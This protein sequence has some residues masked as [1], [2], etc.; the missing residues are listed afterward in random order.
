MSDETANPV[1]L[2]RSRTAERFDGD[3]QSFDALWAT[4]LDASEDERVAFVFALLDC[5]D[6]RQRSE[7]EGRMQAFIDGVVAEATRP[8]DKEQ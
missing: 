7:R 5:Y 8:K 2:I 6:E 3:D 4:L 1:A